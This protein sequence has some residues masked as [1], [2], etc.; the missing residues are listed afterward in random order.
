MNTKEF[1]GI[2]KSCYKSL[3]RL[4]GLD[5]EFF[6]KLNDIRKSYFKYSQEANN[7]NIYPPAK[8]DIIMLY[9]NEL[10]EL[11][12]EAGIKVVFFDIKTVYMKAEYATFMKDMHDITDIIK[13]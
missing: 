5:E 6:N 8:R 12:S 2:T 1:I 9:Y 10:K 4:S 7:I 13:P 11:C 3:S